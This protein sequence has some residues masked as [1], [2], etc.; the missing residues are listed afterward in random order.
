MAAGTVVLRDMVVVA[1][2]VVATEAVD[3]VGWG[4]AAVSAVVTA[5]W[6]V[7]TAGWA[8]VTA[9]WVDTVGWEGWE[10]WAWGGWEEA[11][12]DKWGRS[13]VGLQSKRR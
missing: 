10:G 8:V 5:G 9:G 7:V 1:S 11:C 6:A 12:M 3:M 2:T 4:T 13:Q